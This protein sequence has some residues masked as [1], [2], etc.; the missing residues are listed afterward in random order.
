MIE[1][2]KLAFKT[3]LNKGEC[4]AA[5][6]RDRRRLLSLEQEAALLKH[7]IGTYEAEIE[8]LEKMKITNQ[9]LFLERN[10]KI[11]FLLELT[12]QYRIP[13][14]EETV[15]NFLILG[16]YNSTENLSDILKTF[17]SAYPFED[18]RDVKKIIFKI[19][20]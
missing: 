1:A 6:I 15:L 8:G 19:L 10:K 14:L 7:L 9:Q 4:T 12:E 3:T 13:N 18:L 20:C 2:E 11:D 5:E 17:K 16:N